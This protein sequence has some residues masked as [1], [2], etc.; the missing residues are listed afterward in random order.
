L[1]LRNPQP[2][3]F[4]PNKVKFIHYDSLGSTNVEAENLFAKGQTTP[5]WVRADQQT[6]GRGR[7]GREWSSPLGNFYGT[8][9][10]KFDG[11][12]DQAAKLSFVAAVAVAN[13]LSAYSVSVQPSLKWPN[14]VLM[15]GRKIA[16]LLLEA[17]AGFVLIG[18]G[19]NL[20]S[21]PEGGNIPA[22]HLLE[23]ID[24]SAL[25]RD[26]PEFT[27]AESFLAILAR[28]F[29]QAYR[30]NLAYGFSAT[31]ADWTKLASG[32]PGPVTVRLPSESFA[33]EAESLLE[34]GALRVRLQDGTIRDVHAGDVF[35]E[36]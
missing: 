27:G 26:E 21:H 14:D 32:L 3:R 4:S 18:I 12:P 30:K 22:T 28:C 29:D 24:P 1:D 23:H 25:D 11:S 33:G 13:A 36:S 6:A 20:V 16:G 34:N 2:K 8:A 17:K 10:Y 7:R 31:R 9:C 5:F 35:F 19:V 15:D